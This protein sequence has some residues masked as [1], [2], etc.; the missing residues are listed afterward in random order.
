MI[1][2]R[3]DGCAKHIALDDIRTH[4]GCHIGYPKTRTF[5]PHCKW[6]VCTATKATRGE[7]LSHA[8]VHFDT[9]AFICKCG[10]AFKRK[11]DRSTHVRKCIGKRFYN[12][13]DVLFQGLP[14][15]DIILDE[16][17]G[18]SNK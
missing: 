4:I 18:K 1:I 12:A 6:P 13:L 3:W 2:C 16:S 7:L 15:R 11:Y 10:K 17:F 8:M 9:R 5:Y 14:E